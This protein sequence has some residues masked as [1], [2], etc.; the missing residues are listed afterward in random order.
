MN[1]VVTGAAGFLG[2]ECVQQLRAEGHRVTTTDRA[3]A[4]DHLGDLSD[5]AFVARLPDADTVL[6]CAAVQYVTPK[7]P[8]LRRAEYFHTN[9]IVTAHRL[10]ERYRGTGTHL[11]NIG[12]SMMYEQCNKQMYGVDSAFADQGVYSA[13]KLEA[14]R[15]LQAAF[16]D[17]AS[18][19]PCIIGGIGREGLFRG[20]VNSIGS[21]GIAVF[22]GSGEHPTHMV[23]VEDAASLIVRVVVQRARGLFNAAGPSPLSIRQWVGVVADELGLPAP[24][25]LRLPLTPLR[26]LSAAL[27]Y[28]L[29]AREQLLMLAQP[30]VLDTTGSRALGW[31]PRYDNER[32]VR[33]IA[34]YI[35][36]SKAGALRQS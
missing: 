20:F 22:P 5:K 9:N 25:L 12:T 33:D 32:I 19:Q 4:V 13:S 2:R 8:L 30:H 24:K 6:H 23:H 21:F 34:R 14:W 7:L 10:I 28:R 18:V 3:G 29:L 27:G 35:A 11:L 36:S 17:A 1:I 26:L 31:Q 16:P 15:L